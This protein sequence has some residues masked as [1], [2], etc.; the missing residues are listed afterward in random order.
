MS[1]KLI[2][3]SLLALL[4]GCIN[5]KDPYTWIIT[6][7]DSSFCKPACDRMKTLSCEEGLD[8]EDGT[9]CEQFCIESQNNGHNLNPECVSRISNCD[10]IPVCTSGIGR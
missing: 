2:I 4:A 3:L 10:E 8:F 5:Q 7:Q 9:T 1:Q 6:P